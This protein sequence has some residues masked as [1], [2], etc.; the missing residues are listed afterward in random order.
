MAA[1]FLA[2]Q[3]EQLWDPT[4]YAALD[5]FPRVPGA[6]ELRTND[7]RISYSVVVLLAKM[8]QSTQLPALLP[9]TL[10]EHV[11]LITI[12]PCL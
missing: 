12:L 1:R 9:P 8:S 3:I 10:S 7:K 6:Q 11:D 5:P 4:A 2:R